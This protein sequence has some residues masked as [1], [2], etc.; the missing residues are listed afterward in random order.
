MRDALALA[1]VIVL[2]ACTTPNPAFDEELVGVVDDAGSPG[3]LACAGGDSLELF[4]LGFEPSGCG[5]PFELAGMIHTQE[6]GAFTIV[7]CEGEC[8]CEPEVEG[9]PFAL[10]G[11]VPIPVF[12]PC[13][14]LHTEIAG[15]CTAASVTIRASDGRLLVHAGPLVSPQDVAGLSVSE[16]LVDACDCDACDAG[17]LVPGTY[18]LTFASP[19]D[20]VGPLRAGEMAELSMAVDDDDDDDS[21][22]VVKALS[23]AIGCDCSAR[24]VLQWS[25]TRG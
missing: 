1:M 13:V 17:G 10:H 12:S 14:A 24:R 2:P 19:D 22:Y 5:E 6:A 23:T 16:S 21:T 8:P 15:D 9:L 4:T 25:V 11:D 3:E 18:G 20:E 7:E